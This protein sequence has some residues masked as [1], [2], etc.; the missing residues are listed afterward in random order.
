MWFHEFKHD[1][2]RVIARRDDDRVRLYSRP[3]NDLTARFSLIVE[4]MARAR[5]PAR[6]APREFR[7]G[8]WRWLPERVAKQASQ[9]ATGPTCRPMPVFP[10]VATV[11]AGGCRSVVRRCAQPVGGDAVN[12]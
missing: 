3:G 10:H 1:G 9:L 4:A 11:V 6:Q 12:R 8:V 2:F 7:A 5:T